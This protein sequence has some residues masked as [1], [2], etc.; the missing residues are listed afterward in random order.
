MVS[1]IGTKPCNSG[2]DIAGLTRSLPVTMSV[3]LALYTR[4]D[5]AGNAVK[6]VVTVPSGVLVE[7]LLMTVC[8]SQVVGA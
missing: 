6:S 7:I 2:L 3:H 1:A 8:L 5:L 4:P